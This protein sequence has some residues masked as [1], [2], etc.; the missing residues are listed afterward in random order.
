MSWKG[1][2]LLGWRGWVDSPAGTDH[3]A[4]S[5]PAGWGLLRSWIAH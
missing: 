3:S 5:P 1:L 4:S 2:L